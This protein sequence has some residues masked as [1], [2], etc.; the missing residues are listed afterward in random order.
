MA[1]V[2]KAVRGRVAHL[3]TLEDINTLISH[4]E[5]L[6]EALRNVVAIVVGRMEAEVCSIYLVDLSK[7]RIILRATMGLDQAA[8]GKVSMGIDEGLVG[9]VIERMRPVM[10]VDA[11]AHPRFKYFPET[12]EERFH[13]FLGV[14]LTEKRLPLGVLV[15]QTSR[16]REF[17][18]DEIR[19]LK[20][21]SGQVAGII[22]RARLA[23]SLKHKERERIQYRRHLVRALKRL[24]TYERRRREGA[25]RRVTQRWR[26]RLTGRAASPGFGHGKVHMVHPRMALQAVKKR[27]TKNPA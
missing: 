15:I 8:V 17:S 24:R 14:P 23:E 18:P 3:V 25:E 4:S 19:L 16:R 13:S 1:K 2:K 20:A 6:Q 7:E 12:G 22:A 21:I 10:V 5:D 11:P 27:R 9:L 26:G